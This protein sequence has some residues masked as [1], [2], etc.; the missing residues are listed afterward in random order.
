MDQI[1][2]DVREAAY[3]GY[4]KWKGWS[5]EHNANSELY[6][7]EMKRANVFP[8]AKVLEVGF[9]NGDFLSWAQA[10][11]YEICGV[12]INE[13]FV[14]SAMARNFKVWLGDISL[15]DFGSSSPFDVIVVFDVLEHL[16]KGEIL[17]TLRTF[18]NLLKP[19]G[20]VIA[21]FPNAGSPFG[22][23]AQ[24][25]DITHETPLSGA[26]MIQLGAM[27]GFEVI[28]AGNAARSYKGGNRK[29]FSIAKRFAYFVRDCCEIF[30]GY[31]YIGKRVPFD[32]C[33]TVILRHI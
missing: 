2:P 15:I 24:F 28:Y 22:V 5:G 1:A 12:E 23:W 31:L 8:P 11:G 17:K 29:G 18:H 4:A 21:R 9:G 20:S 10:A 14:T 13:E 32:I 16:T 25:G 19:G 7:T 3:S 30:F 26:R 33:M 6:K 27:T